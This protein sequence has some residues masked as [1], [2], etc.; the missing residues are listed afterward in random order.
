MGPW[1]LDGDVRAVEIHQMC[2]S[3]YKVLEMLIGCT[4]QRE[5]SAQV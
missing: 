5:S 2:V 3:A 4:R 1:D